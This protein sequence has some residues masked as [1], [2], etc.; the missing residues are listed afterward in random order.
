MTPPKHSIPFVD[1]QAQHSP[2]KAAI[3]S[4]WEAILDTTS[5]ISGNW[6][7]K[8]ENRFAQFH[9]TEY[10]VAVSNGTTALELALRAVTAKPPYLSPR[11]LATVVQRLLRIP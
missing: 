11:L 2:I 9:D 5:F 10:C 7:E 1:L 6:V 8:F 3:I 4:R